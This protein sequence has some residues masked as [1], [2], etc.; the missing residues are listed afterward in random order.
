MN[1]RN[2][3]VSVSVQWEITGNKHHGYGKERKIDRCLRREPWGE[4]SL[5]DFGSFS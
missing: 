3:L 1:L 2:V 5:K 4:E